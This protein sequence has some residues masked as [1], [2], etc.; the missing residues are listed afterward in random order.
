MKLSLVGALINDIKVMVIMV[1]NNLRWAP[2][3]CSRNGPRKRL[4]GKTKGLRGLMKLGELLVW[5]KREPNL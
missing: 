4:K 1:H 5:V 3:M 2:R